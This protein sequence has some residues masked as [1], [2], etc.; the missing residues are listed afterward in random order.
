MQSDNTG[1][2]KE[3]IQLLKEKMTA[4]EQSYVLVESEDNGDE[5]V[6]FHF[7]GKY[8]G[9]EVIYDAALYTLRLSHSSEVYEIAEHK[10]AKRFPEFKKIDY[11]EDENGDLEALDDIEEEIGL[12]MAEVMMDLEEEESIKVQEH[13]EIDPNVN[14]GIGLD[15]GLNVSEVTPK[16]LDK[17]IR[18]FNDDTIKLDPNLYSFQSEEDDQ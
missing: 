12:Y 1:Y 16:V 17:F 11:E 13:I 6:N 8:E 14:Y 3:E 4:F 15:I 2:S 5:Y 18:E 9:R 10:A 7:A